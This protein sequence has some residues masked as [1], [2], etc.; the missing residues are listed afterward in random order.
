MKK[1]QKTNAARLLDRA[2]I[3]Y[4]LIAYEV[5]ENDLSAGHLAAT[6][7]EDIN[8]VFKTLV[9][10]GEKTKHFVCVVPGNSEVDLKKAAKVSG[11]KKVDLIAMK[12]LLAT[13]GYIRGGCSPIGMKKPFP[14]F[15]HESCMMFTHIYISAGQR[16]LQLKISPQALITYV[17]ATVCDLIKE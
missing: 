14:T 12:D 13:T 10:F 9:L 7:G 17:E 6:I 11:N 1:I 2:K 15:I 16:G 5:D 8:Q 3:H 4:E